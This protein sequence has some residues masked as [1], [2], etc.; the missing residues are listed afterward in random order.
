MYFDITEMTDLSGEMAHIY[1]VTLKGEEQTLLEQF[2][3]DNAE[4]EDELD[5]ILPLF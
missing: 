4:Y 2:F 5:S 1:S 3:E